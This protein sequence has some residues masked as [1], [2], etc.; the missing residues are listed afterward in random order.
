MNKIHRLAALI[1]IFSLFCSCG[2]KVV[3]NEE[4]TDF[5]LSKSGVT[6]SD[7]STAL[8]GTSLNNSLTDNKK[9]IHSENGKIKITVGITNVYTAAQYGFIL[10]IDG[11][12]APFSTNESTE[13]KQMHIINMSQNEKNREITIIFSDEYF[14]VDKDCYV[15]IATVLNPNYIIKSTDYI[16]FLPHH[17]LTAYNF[18]IVRK[19]AGDSPFFS[20]SRNHT[21]YSLP[22]TIEAMYNQTKGTADDPYGTSPLAKKTNSLD[23]TTEFLLSSNN[24]FEVFNSCFACQKGID[25]TLK[26]GCL[27]KSDSFRLSLYVNNELIPA[28]DGCLYCDITTERDKLKVIEAT[29]PSDCLKDCGE[30]NSIYLIAVPL[31]PSL[32]ENDYVRPLKATSKLLYISE[33]AEKVNK[34]NEKYS[35]PEPTEAFSELTK[36]FETQATPTKSNTNSENNKPETKSSHSPAQNSTSNYSIKNARNVW[37]FENGTVLIQT[38][39]WTIHIFDPSKGT[40]SEKYIYGGSDIKKIDNGFAVI[41]TFEFSYKIYNTELTLLN[42]GSLPYSITEGDGGALTVSYD[43]KSLIYEVMK[44]G[45]LEKDIYIDTIPQSSPK[46][47]VFCAG[48]GAKTGS[49]TV[50]LRADSSRKMPK[51]RLFKASSNSS[52]AVIG[53]RESNCTRQNL[54]FRRKVTNSTNSY[55]LLDLTRKVC[56]IFIKV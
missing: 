21:A 14:A 7:N 15:S 31:K 25:F 12:R 48:C 52:A 51:I 22:V 24:N 26:I 45:S 30:F 17:A 8:Y 3:S 1:L 34:L 13:E 4:S 18:Y 11:V 41:D 49:K 44:S 47:V 50:A 39:D 40:L 33:N 29:I 38:R 53:W 27:G 5:D 42:E 46:R 10:F 19:S 16:N 2:K 36:V 43:G 56:Y 20:V 23:K 28:F 9:T 6:E 32:N 37:V 55:I 54:I 35:A